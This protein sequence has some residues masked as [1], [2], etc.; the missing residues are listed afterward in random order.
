VHTQ[1]VEF[2]ELRDALEASFEKAE[3]K[4]EVVFWIEEQVAVEGYGEVEREERF[5]ST[6]RE[7]WKT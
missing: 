7:L 6:Q 4:R 3:E 5:Q 1:E 2:A